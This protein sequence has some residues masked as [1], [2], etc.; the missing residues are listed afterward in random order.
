MQSRGSLPRFGNTPQRRSTPS[1]CNPAFSMTRAEAGVLNVAY[2]TDTPNARLTKSPID[3][4]RKYLRHDASPPGR[5]SQH[6]AESQTRRAWSPE[7][8]CA[9]ELPVA[10]PE[11]N[12]GSGGVAVVQAYIGLRVLD[13]HM[14]SPG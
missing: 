2:V 8:E 3:D 11:Q 5:S 7:I 10:T 14:R 1:R 13:G 9:H 6:V 12:I 4:V